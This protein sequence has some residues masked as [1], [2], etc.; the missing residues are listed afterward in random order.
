M[1]LSDLKPIQIDL[2]PSDSKRENRYMAFHNYMRYYNLKL[3]D[4]TN[5]LEIEHTKSK[6]RFTESELI[7]E[8]RK[9]NIPFCKEWIK[10]LKSVNTQRYNPVTEYFENMKGKWKPGDISH[11]DKLCSCITPTAIDERID[12]TNRTNSMFRKWLY[13]VAA[14]A[15]QI[16]HNPVMLIFVSDMVQGVG[17]SW[18]CRFLAGMLPKIKT[19]DPYLLKKIENVSRA[20][21]KYFLIMFDELIGLRQTSEINFIKSI[22]EDETN[23]G[24]NERERHRIASFIGSADKSHFLVDNAGSRRFLILQIENIDYARYTTQVDIDQLWAEATYH[25]TQSDRQT[26]IFDKTD[27][28][29]MEIYN[30]NFA[31]VGSLI[32]WIKRNYERTENESEETEWLRASEIL[33]ELQKTMMPQHLKMQTTP[34]RIAKILKKLSFIYEDRKRLERTN[35]PVPVYLIKRKEI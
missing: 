33:K 20:Q 29:E 8:M 7:I 10:E 1:D 9:Q 30:A 5:L 6:K 12:Y 11:I 4:I 23:I 2:K 26:Y 3:N 17:K 27:F 28:T 16:R 21:N 34:E 25:A 35:Y 14:G 18:L 15:L 13:A 19:S 32:Y 22:L 24:T 31:D